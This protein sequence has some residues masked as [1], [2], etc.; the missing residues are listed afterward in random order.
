MCISTAASSLRDEYPREW[1]EIPDMPQQRAVCHSLSESNVSKPHVEEKAA[2]EHSSFQIWWPF[3][4][5]NTNS[6]WLFSLPV[7]LLYSNL[8][9]DFFSFTQPINVADIFSLHTFPEQL[10]PFFFLQ[11]PSTWLMAAKSTSPVQ[12]LLMSSGFINQLLSH[13]SS[14]NF[15]SNMP[16]TELTILP[17]K[18]ANIT[19]IIYW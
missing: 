18:P 12:I 2:T 13:I 5:S 9:T 4:L 17:S 6:S 8:S 19:T 15:K 16:N 10:C 7:W 1:G 3:F 11:L 14:Q